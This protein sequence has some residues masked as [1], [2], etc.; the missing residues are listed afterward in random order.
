M[1]KKNLSIVFTLLFLIFFDLYLYSSCQGK[2]KE[3]RIPELSL[4]ISELNQGFLPAHFQNNSNSPV[5]N[6][7]PVPKDEKKLQ[8]FSVLLI[9]YKKEEGKF[10]LNQLHWAKQ[11]IP[12]AK[13]LQNDRL[14]FSAADLKEIEDG[15]D[16]QPMIQTGEDFLYRFFVG[17]H[18]EAFEDLE[19]P[20]EEEEEALQ[21]YYANFTSLFKT[22]V[23][24]DLYLRGK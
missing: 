20:Q 9:L 11:N 21:D 17:L 22:R 16:Y 1:L 24:Q 15:L 19:L 14:R 2:D 23:F 5:L 18:A 8:Y 13:F 10:I 7:F 4:Q 3:I 12:L 6:V